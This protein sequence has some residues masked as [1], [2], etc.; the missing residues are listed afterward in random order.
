MAYPAEDGFHVMDLATKAEKV[1]TGVNGFDLH[2]SP[3]GKQIAYVGTS[4]NVIDSVF[5]VNSDGTQMSQVSEPSYESIIGWSSD[6]KELFFV[7]PYTGGAGWKVYSYT[8][9]SASTQ[10]LF[11]IDNGSYKALNAALSPDGQW[12]AYRSQQLNNLYL[13]HPDGSKMHLVLDSPA[14]GIGD[15]EWSQSGWLAV[16]LSTDSDNNT[17]TILVR[18]EDCQVYLLPNL[19]GEVQGIFTP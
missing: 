19:H 4:E 1:L 11:T 9:A 5:I 6:S 3:D 18:P 10:D 17:A 16:S 8:P 7:V 15:L 2:W 12:I 13:V 14:Q